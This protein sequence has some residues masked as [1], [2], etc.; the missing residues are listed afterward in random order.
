MSDRA[1]AGGAPDPT[2]RPA[3][4][5]VHGGR[6]DPRAGAPLTEPVTFTSTY[7]QDGPVSYARFGNPTWTAFEDVLGE[8]EGGSALAFASGM[9]AVDA[10]LSLVPQGGT[11]VAPRGSYNGTVAWLREAEAS[12]R[13][14]VRWVDVADTEAVLAALPGADLLWVESPTNPLLEVADLPALATAARALRVRTAADNTFATPLG[15]RPLADGV[16]VV[17]HSATKYLAGHSDVL[18]GATVTRDDALLQRLHTR[19]TLG[20]AVPGPMEAWLALRGVRTLAVRFERACANAAVIA[21]RLAEHPSV[22]RSRYPGTGGIISI[23]VGD[24]ADETG[25]IAEAVAATTRLWVP[26]TSLGGVESQIERR[27]RQPGEPT[28]TPT[29]LLRLSVGIEDVEDLWADLA[30]A[31]EAA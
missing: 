22:R 8:L 31:L 1:R 27:R 4:R 29:S 16:D 14:V 11:V 23:E 9:A 24:P 7:V 13:A 30:A 19:R 2:P 12:G 3:T 15:A 21:Q 10:V 28:T 20:G 25:A 6:P 18:L 5:L 26:S 17:V